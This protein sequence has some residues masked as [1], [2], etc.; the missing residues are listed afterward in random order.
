VGHIPLL[1]SADQV[2]QG[3]NG[4]GSGAALDPILCTY[5]QSKSVGAEAY[6]GV[7]TALYFSA[8]GAGCKVIQITSPDPGDGKTTLAANLAVSIAQSGKKTL[9]IDADFR[10]PKQHKVF[11]ISPKIGLATAL[12]DEASVLDAAQPSGI[13]NLMVLPCGPVP[14]DPS[15]LLTSPRFKELLDSLHGQYDF[16]L[17][18]TPPLLAVTDPCAVAARVDGVLLVIRLSKSGRP[19]AERAKEILATLGA[20]VLGVVVNGTSRETSSGGYGYG[21][22]YK[23]YGY[24]YADDYHTSDVAEHPTTPT[25]TEGL[26][27]DA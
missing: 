25:N 15:E 22:S 4:N 6:R 3:A 21:Y 24:G 14:P 1:S 7:R 27:R 10:K 5:Y 20:T 18:D 8:R 26:P 11:G 17:I 16:V 13:P 23:D 9:L 2:L 19:H 12:M